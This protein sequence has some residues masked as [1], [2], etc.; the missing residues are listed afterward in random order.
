M[1]DPETGQVTETNERKSQRLSTV[2]N[3][4]ATMTKFV[5]DAQE[6]KVFY[7]S[8]VR[9]QSSQFATQTIK[10]IKTKLRAPTQA[11]LM[12][13]ALDMEEGNVIQHRDY[14]KLEEEKR[15]RARVVRATVEGPVLR[16]VSK[17][18]EVTVREDA[19]ALPSTS[20]HDPRPG[21]QYHQWSQAAGPSQFVVDFQQPYASQHQPP[22]SNS[23]HP[24]YT[25]WY[26]RPIYTPPAPAPLPAS[27]VLARKEKVEKNYVV[28]ETQQSENAP[29]PTWRQTMEAMFGDHV[30]WDEVRVFSGKNRPFCTSIPPNFY[31]LRRPHHLLAIPARPRE[32]CPIT[33]LPA[34]YID[35]RTGTPYANVQAFQEIS[36][37]LKHEYVWSEELGCYVG[38]DDEDQ[39]EDD[40]EPERPAV[41][42]AMET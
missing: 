17:I 41:D 26:G 24:Q 20:S 7:R 10:K 1:I 18:E 16:W 12:T 40:E 4:S 30:K 27:P 39:Y 6:K 22:P 38:P 23:Q 21:H 13:R 36:K 8:F 29:L 25:D 9:A 34:I 37:V 33:G 31:I 15:R 2:M 32:R 19:P 35:P 28:I 42:E 3:R 14:L 11:E 5:K